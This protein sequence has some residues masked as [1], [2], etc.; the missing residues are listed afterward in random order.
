V[1][2]VTEIFLIKKLIKLKDALA[3]C[4]NGMSERAELDIVVVKT[5]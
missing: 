4:M 1:T 2:C 3:I 5:V